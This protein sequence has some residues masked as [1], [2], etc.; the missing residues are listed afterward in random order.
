MEQKR[1]KEKDSEIQKKE[2]GLINF[3]FIS[4]MD[5]E[6]VQEV[7]CGRHKKEEEGLKYH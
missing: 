6:G 5:S 7:V 2:I 3:V 4:G 1:T